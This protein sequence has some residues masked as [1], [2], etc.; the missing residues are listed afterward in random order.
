MDV[1]SGEVR[2]NLNEDLLLK[3]K[4]S[5]DT[6]PDLPQEVVHSNNES[7]SDEKEQGKKKSSALCKYSSMIPEKVDLISS[8]WTL[9]SFSVSS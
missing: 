6:S 8:A 5:A 1:T 7:E 4:S 9:L 3:E 2:V